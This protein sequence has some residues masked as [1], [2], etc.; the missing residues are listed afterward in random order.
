MLAAEPDLLAALIGDGDTTAQLEAAIAELA[1]DP[2]EAARLLI[3]RGLM[4]FAHSCCAAHAVEELTELRD[5]CSRKII[6]L[7]REM[8]MV[9]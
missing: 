7:G 1:D 3:Q 6:E 9:N 2:I 5:F 8:E 4:E